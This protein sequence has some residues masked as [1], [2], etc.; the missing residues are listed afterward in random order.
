MCSFNILQGPEARPEGRGQTTLTATSSCASR[1]PFLNQVL[2]GHRKPTSNPTKT[3]QRSQSQ[4]AHNSITTVP[5]H[6]PHKSSPHFLCGRSNTT[7]SQPHPLHTFVAFPLALQS[8]QSHIGHAK[9]ISCS[10]EHQRNEVGSVGRKENY[11]IN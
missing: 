1:T 5:P 9:L 2:S 10:M 11:K 8:A 7:S 3:T 4:N 6:R